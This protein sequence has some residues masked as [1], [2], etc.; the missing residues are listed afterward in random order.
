MTVH[1]LLA[2]YNLLVAALWAVSIPR[3]PYAASLAAAHG[4]AALLPVLWASRHRRAGGEG[5]LSGVGAVLW[6]YYPL[7]LLAA[8]WSEMDLFRLSIHPV[9]YDRIVSQL[10]LALFGT[11]WNAVLMPLL[12]AGWVSEAMHFSYL[13]YYPLIFVPPIVLG[14]RGR[15]D[16][17]RDVVYR[18]L[19][20]YLVCY[21]VYLAFPVDGPQYTMPR[22]GGAGALTQGF[23][24]RLSH[25]VT[26]A[27]DTLGTGFPS[28][29][30][31]GAVT[32]AWLGARW[33]PRPVAVLFMLEAA[34]VLVATV[35]TQNH[36][37]V[38]ALA[39]LTLALLLQGLAAPALQ[40][41]LVCPRP[42]IDATPA[43]EPA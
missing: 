31:A 35:Y 40:R 7:V 36:F 32:M 16:A 28:S 24:Y 22:V 38:D 34:A 21:L 19:L 8:F 27:A 29:H 12:P 3:A 15:R 2:G 13:A 39:G 18:L 5:A 30:V 33:M 26:A 25:S 42:S 41:W 11:H 1:L 23:F 20:T 37:A 17:L 6:Q 10:D 4:V 43:P 9:P 14:L